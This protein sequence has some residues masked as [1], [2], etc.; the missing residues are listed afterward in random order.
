MG[1]AKT[2]RLRDRIPT[3]NPMM[4]ITY[5][6]RD[7]GSGTVAPGP[8]VIAPSTELPERLNLAHT[9]STYSKA[10]AVR[11]IQS[12]AGIHEANVERLKG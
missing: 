10:Q 8:R 6:S 7:D 12:V 4:P 5:S 9:K 3:I 1:R 11:Q 2:L